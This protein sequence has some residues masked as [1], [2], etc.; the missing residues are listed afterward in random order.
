MNYA[1]TYHELQDLDEQ[2]QLYEYEDD[3]DDKKSDTDDKKSDTDDKKSDTD[4][5]TNTYTDDKYDK[6]KKEAWRVGFKEAH[7]KGYCY[8]RSLTLFAMFCNS[9]WEVELRAYPDECEY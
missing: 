9:K 7:T 8:S 3:T 4:T 1:K 5:D 6:A 2:H